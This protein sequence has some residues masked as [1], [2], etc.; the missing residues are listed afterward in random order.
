MFLLIS[1]PS[2]VSRPNCDLLLV[3][4]NLWVN[5][6]ISLYWFKLLFSWKNISSSKHYQAEMKSKA[7]L[8]FNRLHPDSHRDF[9]NIVQTAR[10]RKESCVEGPDAS[11]EVTN[12][13][14]NKALTKSTKEDELFCETERKKRKM[15][16]KK[17][18]WSKN[19]IQVQILLDYHYSDSLTEE[20]RRR[21]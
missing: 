5:F 19:L 10:K 2:S 15:V 12:M 21:F 7:A 9:Q 16:K 18:T 3:T 14:K 8:R 20:W 17:I 6:E 1:T 4:N 13:I 11:D